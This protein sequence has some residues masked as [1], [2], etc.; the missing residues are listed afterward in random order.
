[1]VLLT[2]CPK[3]T[4]LKSIPIVENSRGR[5]EEDVQKEFGDYVKLNTDLING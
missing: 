2:T 1:M 5:G 4:K 3:S